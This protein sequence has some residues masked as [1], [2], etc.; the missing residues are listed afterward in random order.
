MIAL[1][2]APV[3]RDA[4][5]VV[6]EDKFGLSWRGPLSA[7]I[8]SHLDD[9]DCLEVIA[10]SYANLP[11][12]QQQGLNYLS[13]QIPVYLH[14]IGL[15]LASCSAPS[16]RHLDQLKRIQEQLKPQI[17]SE[18]LAFVR[19]T[20]IDGNS[21]G[22]MLEIGHLAAPARNQANIDACCENIKFANL[23]LGAQLEL[24]NIAALAT[25]LGCEFSETDWITQIIRRSG[26]AL[27]LDLENLYANALNSAQSPFE[28]LMAL[29]LEQ[30]R[31]VHLSGGSWV[32][33]DW[34][35]AQHSRF[36]DDHKHDIPTVVFALLERLAQLV[37]QPLTII[38]ERDGNFPSMQELLAQLNQAK[39]AVQRGRSKPEHFTIEPISPR[40]ANRS[41]SKDENRRIEYL[42]TQLYC[43]ENFRRDFQNAPM[44]HLT[45]LKLSQ[46]H[47]ELTDFNWV[48]T[49]LMAGSVAI[50]NKSIANG[51]FPSAEIQEQEP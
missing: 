11:L 21:S 12:Q 6:A 10:Q 48:G 14:S 27:L 31:T 29:P 7:G 24:E 40:M 35:S 51:G 5:A 36:L 4:V 49:H 26:A 17:I 2:A 44:A 41:I 23:H 18:H 16:L 47:E 15:G 34:Q 33:C 32:H 19:A 37:P 9:I 20:P 25:P 39:Q 1:V 13:G 30:V 8:L 3:V 45:E 50:K 43:D 46:L 42:L 38:I 22:H 28:L